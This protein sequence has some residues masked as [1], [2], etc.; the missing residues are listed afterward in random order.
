MLDWWCDLEHLGQGGDPGGNFHRPRDAQG[1]HAFAKS[2][3]AN[4]GDVLVFS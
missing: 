1:L 3:V 4:L 2:Q